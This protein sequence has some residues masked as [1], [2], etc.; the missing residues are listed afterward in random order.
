MPCK[1]IRT[2]RKFL[3]FLP[4]RRCLYIEPFNVAFCG[5]NHK[6]TSPLTE[7]A[8]QTMKIVPGLFRVTMFRRW[9]LFPFSGLTMP[10]RARVRE[11]EV[12]S[13]HNMRLN[14]ATVQCLCSRQKLR[15]ARRCF[16]LVQVLPLA[17][18]Q[19]IGTDFVVGA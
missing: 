15:P 17:G 16:R 19:S 1:S 18:E 6:G 11:K 3:E 8:S 7:M 10:R 12:S 9:Y 14:S 4:T 5:K 2:L 13:K